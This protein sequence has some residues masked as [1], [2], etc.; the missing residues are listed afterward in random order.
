L[1]QL[2]SEIDTTQTEKSAFEELASELEWKFEIPSIAKKSLDEAPSIRVAELAT[3]ANENAEL[4]IK[5][6]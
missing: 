4:K 2:S 6:D 5:L 3:R 1:R